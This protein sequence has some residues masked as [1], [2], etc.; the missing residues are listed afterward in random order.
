MTLIISCITKNKNILC[1]SD[2]RTI[3]ENGRI[4]NENKQKVFSFDQRCLIGFSGHE[5]ISKD[6]LHY[7]CTQIFNNHKIWYPEIAFQ[8]LSSIDNSMGPNTIS[9]ISFQVIPIITNL[10]YTMLFLVI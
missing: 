4:I 2:Q 7:L 6:L 3:D 8:N 10:Y 1:C 5:D 9:N